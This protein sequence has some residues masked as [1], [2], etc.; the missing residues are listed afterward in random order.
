[1]PII[2]DYPVRTAVSHERREARRQLGVDEHVDFVLLAGYLRQYKQPSFIAELAREMRARAL[3]VDIWV[4]GEP[5]TAEAKAAYEKLADDGVR[6]KFTHL[7]LVE[8][9]MWIAAASLLLVPYGHGTHSGMVVRA[10]CIGTEV[11]ASP[12]LS[13]EVGELRVGPALALDA[14]VWVDEI[15]ARLQRPP[16]PIDRPDGRQFRDTTLAA[17]ATLGVAGSAAKGGLY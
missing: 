3:H 16:I 15:V 4:V 7:S 11:L 14:G 6:L 10:A 9:N 17:Y 5:I 2:P 12:S 8:L 1:M 13:E